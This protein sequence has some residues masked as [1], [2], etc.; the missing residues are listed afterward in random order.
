MDETTIGEVN[1]DISAD[2]PVTA[3]CRLFRFEDES[4]L[5]TPNDFIFLFQLAQL[6][7]C[8]GKQYVNVMIGPFTAEFNGHYFHIHNTRRDV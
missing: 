6:C 2:T 7:K 1:T 5:C 3:S 4:T 8:F